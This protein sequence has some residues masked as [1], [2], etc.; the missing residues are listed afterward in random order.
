MLKTTPKKQRTVMVDD[1]EDELATLPVG[2]DIASRQRAV[3]TPPRSS[4]MKSKKSGRHVRVQ[5]SDSETP[6]EEDGAVSDSSGEGPLKQE[7]PRQTQT[8]RTMSVPGESDS[9]DD[10]DELA[11]NDESKPARE[12][13]SSQSLPNQ[14]APADD[15]EEDPLVTPRSSM[16]RRKGRRIITLDDE[17]ESVDDESVDDESVDD[18]EERETQTPAKRRKITKHRAVSVPSESSEEESDVAPVQH[19]KRMRLKNRG[20]SPGSTE[21]RSR[22]ST[23]E[24]THRTEKEKRMELLRRRRAGE[25]D[26]TLDDLTPSADEGE[27]AL[28]DT[29][30]ELQALDVFDDESESEEEAPPKKKSKKKAK[31]RRTAREPSPLGDGADSDDENFIDDDDD[32][33]GVPDEA[34][35]LMPLEFTRASRKPLK[36]HFKDAVEWLVH[37]RINPGFDRDN[38]MYLTAWRRLSDEVTGLANSKFI[39]SVWRPD[40]YKAL[41]ARPYIEQLQLAPSHLATDMSHCQ[42]C[43]RSGHPATWTIQFKGKPYDPKTLDEVESDSEDEDS[44]EGIERGTSREASHFGPCLIHIHNSRCLAEIYL[45]PTC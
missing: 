38:E 17:D 9:D 27:G 5:D 3:P 45:P 6:V 30:E 44:E 43:G 26:L 35:H 41:K 25:K 24:K 1:D 8:R 23:A 15:S 36:Q 18:D 32:T 39:S 13:R 29:D 33:L 42:A 20:S 28:Y 19:K 21:A 31:E 12:F 2:R 10:D 11:E 14:A 7:T 16:P 34:L 40:F 37:R 22:R 4:F